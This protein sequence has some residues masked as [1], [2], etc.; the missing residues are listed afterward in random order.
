MR[1][2]GLLVMYSIASFCFT[3]FGMNCGEVGSEEELIPL[4]TVQTGKAD[5]PSYYINTG[6][7]IGCDRSYQGEFLREEF[8]HLY[9]FKCRRLCA[10]PS[11]RT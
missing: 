4:E 11:R 10:W 8:A 5:I 2:I 1:K 9:T 3:L 7:T 6:H